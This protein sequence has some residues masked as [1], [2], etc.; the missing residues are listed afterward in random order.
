MIAHGD[1]EVEGG[2][3]EVAAGPRVTGGRFGE[4]GGVGERAGRKRDVLPGGADERLVAD[5]GIDRSGSA[6]PTGMRPRLE[7]DASCD[8]DALTAPLCGCCEAQPMRSA[9][10]T[11]IPSGPRT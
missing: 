6:L 2:V 8:P 11:M 7:L 9:S 5:L 1:A 4:A 3:G 10:E